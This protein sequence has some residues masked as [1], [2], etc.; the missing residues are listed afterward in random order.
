MGIKTIGFPKTSVAAINSF[1]SAPPRMPNSHNI[2]NPRMRAH[3]KAAA[4]WNIA[5]NAAKVKAKARRF[6]RGSKSATWVKAM[7]S[8]TGAHNPTNNAYAPAPTSP[9]TVN[10]IGTSRLRRS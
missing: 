7:V 1:T 6:S 9:P 10:G 3:I 5:E 4:G 8:N 2:Q